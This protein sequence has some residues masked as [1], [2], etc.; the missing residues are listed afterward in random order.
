MADVTI[1]ISAGSFSGSTT[2]STVSVIDG[3]KQPVAVVNRGQFWEGTVPAPAQLQRLEITAGG[4]DA[5][6]PLFER[7]VDLVLEPGQPPRVSPIFDPQNPALP[8]SVNTTQGTSGPQ[9]AVAITLPRLRERFLANYTGTEQL[10]GTYIVPDSVDLPPP[11]DWKLKP[12]TPASLKVKK[13]LLEAPPNFYPAWYAVAFVE[14]VSGFGNLLVFFAPQPGLDQQA[15]WAAAGYPDAYALHV[16]QYVTRAPPPPLARSAHKQ[17]AFQ[18]AQSGKSV[19]FVYP[20]IKFYS[21]RLGALQGAP[22]VP[23]FEELVTYLR[24]RFVPGAAGGSLSKMACASFSYGCANLA[25]FLNAA[26]GALKS[27]ISE[28]YDFDS[29]LIIDKQNYSDRLIA[30]ARAISGVTFRRYAQTW[31]PR[32][33]SQEWRNLI[34]AKMYPLPQARWDDMHFVDLS[35]HQDIANHMLTHALARSSFP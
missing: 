23:L 12:D 33:N 18:V 14:N 13:I 4:T 31:N 25:D 21:G 10:T 17:L 26:P 1:Q 9:V 3:Y 29:D 30:A 11:G 32:F 35:P 19:V 27:K 7:T 5:F 24:L 20:L 28:V 15:A 6:G 16:M 34:N 22:A 8:V 2:Q